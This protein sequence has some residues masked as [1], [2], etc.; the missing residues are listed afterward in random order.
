MA[1]ELRPPV[2]NL[3]LVPSAGVPAGG[4]VAS[5]GKPFLYVDGAGAYRVFLPALRGGAV[6]G[7]GGP[8]HGWSVPLDR[9]FV[10]RPGDSVRTLN[11]ALAQ[12]R[13]LLLTPGVYRLADTVRVK[14]AGTV[15][16]G[17]GLAVLA[18]V[19]ATVPMTVSDA[20]GVRIAGLL[21]DAGPVTSPVLLE[22]GRS[23]GGRSDPRA[24]A[25]VQ[26]VFF[27]IGGADTH[28]STDAG[29]PPEGAQA[30]R[31][32]SEPA[33]GRAATALVVNSDHVQL[34]RVWAW[35]AG[36]GTGAGW[37]AGGPGRGG[38]PADPPGRP[39]VR[40]HDLPAVARDGAGTQAHAIDG[41]GGAA[42]GA[43][44]VAG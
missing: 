23:G 4:V 39:G 12:G 9:F 38:C 11:R 6:P 7:G 25:S 24:P 16:L 37:A 26:D 44:T 41:T 15:V 33:G 36:Q 29:R 17:L 14:W 19:G 13:H 42:Q 2:E 31:S 3:T 40:F 20:R 43:A 8:A 5:R 32:G 27:R 22:L 28:R 18:P 1:A 34:D 35:R 10:A 30:S 21:F